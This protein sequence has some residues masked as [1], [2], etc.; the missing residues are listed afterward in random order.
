[1]ARL[2]RVGVIATVTVIPIRVWQKG[3]NATFRELAIGVLHEGI[4]NTKTERRASGG[5]VTKP[6][7]QRGHNEAAE[8]L[9]ETTPN[10]PVRSRR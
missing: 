9:F 4:H 2:P 7:H 10:V 8:N 5:P 1:M 6:S 3:L